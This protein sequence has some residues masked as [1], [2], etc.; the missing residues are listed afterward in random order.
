METKE[1][2][3][4]CFYLLI[5]FGTILF[6]GYLMCKYGSSSTFDGWIPDYP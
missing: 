2:N 3:L 4:G 5:Y 6:V 1:N